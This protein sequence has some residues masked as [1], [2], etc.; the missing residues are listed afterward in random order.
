ML[1]RKPAKLVK[2]DLVGCNRSRVGGK[3]LDPVLFTEVLRL[4][5]REG[6]YDLADALMTALLHR[7][8]T[9]HH[10]QEASSEPESLDE[11]R[12]D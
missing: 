8:S 1:E 10:V 3:Y 5:A 7:S 4:L 9:P 6:Q 2:M 12:M 11:P